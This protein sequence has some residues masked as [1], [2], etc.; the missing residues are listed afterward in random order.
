MAAAHSLNK[1]STRDMINWEKRVD[2]LIIISNWKECHIHSLVLK[3]I[4]KT[5]ENNNKGQ[6]A[7]FF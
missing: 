1:L 7:L 5:L 3:A 4:L 6:L 2:E